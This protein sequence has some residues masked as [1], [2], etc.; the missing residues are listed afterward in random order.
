MRIYLSTNRAY[1]RNTKI[2]T[3]LY[4]LERKRTSDLM[5]TTRWSV[6][7][8]RDKPLGSMHRVKCKGK[9][10]P[11]LKFIT[12]GRR[13]SAV[14]H[15]RGSGC[16]KQTGRATKRCIERGNEKKKKKKGISRKGRSKGKNAQ[17]DFLGCVCRLANSLAHL[18]SSGGASLP[19]VKRRFFEYNFNHVA[20]VFEKSKKFPTCLATVS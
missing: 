1:R 16:Q 14:V 20:V 3:A 8:S 6:R 7:C 13:P 18:S 12:F 10:W 19:H 5:Q 9:Q 15:R 4:H 11:D 2:R 17:N